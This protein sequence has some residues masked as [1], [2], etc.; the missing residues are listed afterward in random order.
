L[1]MF[2]SKSLLRH[3]EARS[4]LDDMVPGTGFKKFIPDPHHTEGKDALVGH[5]EIKRH[6]ITTGQNYYALLK[7]R[8][9]NKITNVA[10]SRIEQFAPFPFDDVKEAIDSYPNSDICFS[11]EEPMNG[12]WYG[13]VQPR[14][15]T[16]C[17]HSEHHK[18]SLTLLAS[19]PPYSSVATGNKSAHK[20][21][22]EELLAA[23]FNLSKKAS[24]AA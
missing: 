22:L 6:I 7:H 3:P 19:R 21:E 24:D 12:G 13:F 1:I 18:D 10:I 15:R 5:D 16:V 23:S 4:S 9:D 11:Q 20:R 8:R 2:F 17:R 14:L